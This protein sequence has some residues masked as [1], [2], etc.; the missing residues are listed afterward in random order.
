MVVA[1]FGIIVKN[2]VLCSTSISTA[3]LKYCIQDKIVPT[4]HIK[5]V[6][7][8]NT[9]N[10]DISPLVNLMKKTIVLPKPIIVMHIGVNFDS[11]A[12]LSIVIPSAFIEWFYS[13]INIDS[14]IWEMM[15]KKQEKNV[16][17]AR[18]GGWA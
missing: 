10:A 2:Y 6:K 13:T 17:L 8:T 5:A 11:F 16:A 1:V 15:Q 7:P 18:V 4:T 14:N 3:L 9:T 12:A